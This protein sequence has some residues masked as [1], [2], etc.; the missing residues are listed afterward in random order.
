MDLGIAGRVHFIGYREDL[1]PVYSTFDIFVLSSRR[2]GLP[3]SILEAMA[4]GLPVVTTDVAGAKELVIDGITGF[5]LPQ[6]DVNGLT[7]SIMI[8]ADNESLRRR[9][10][11]AG[12]KRVESDFSF[13]GRLRRIEA[14]YEEIIASQLLTMDYSGSVDLAS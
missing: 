4:M 2:E 12:R 6:V 3:N 8:L 13:A 1:L 11:I 14:L 5:V 9:M 7:N 10:G